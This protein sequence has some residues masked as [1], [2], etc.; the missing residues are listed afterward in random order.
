MYL[1]IDA[2]NTRTKAVVYDAAGLLVDSIIS[3]V[4]ELAPIKDLVHRNT[5]EHVIVSTT[6]IRSWNLS[7]LD[8]KGSQIELSHEVPLPIRIVYSTPESLGRDRIAAACG[9]HAL[10]PDKN[11]LVISAG[12]CLTMDMVLA[13]GVY[14][15]GN[16]APGLRMR[17]QAMHE[18]T[19]KLPLVE[20]GKPELVFGDSTVHAL[21][22]GAGLGMVMEIEG[23]FQHAKNAFGKVLIVMTGGDA[24]YLA[25]RIESQIFVA[26]ELV[27]QGLFQILAFN[28]KTT[29]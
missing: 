10:Y 5:I 9:A 12:T 29:Y 18:Y 24:V 20:P 8:I 19:A 22:N 11:C 3:A 7:D 21:Q 6:G 25:D 28:V 1:T 27:T 26:P 23:I 13:G 16:I 4:N 14:L 17:L 15:G 2:G